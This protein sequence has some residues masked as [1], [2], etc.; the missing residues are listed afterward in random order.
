[1]RKRASRR[2]FCGRWSWLN[3]LTKTGLR[4]SGF[5]AHASLEIFVVSEAETIHCG[6][7]DET[8]AQ[9]HE[10]SRETNVVGPV[11]RLVREA[12]GA[13]TRDRPRVSDSSQQVAASGGRS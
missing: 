3:A 12:R 8:R 13:S 9:T 10:S 6:A 11:G 5:S 7:N 4:P 1:G 2:A